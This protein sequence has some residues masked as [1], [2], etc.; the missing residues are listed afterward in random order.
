MTEEYKK[1]VCPEAVSATIRKDGI[2]YDWRCPECGRG[3]GDIDNFCPG[4]GSELDW[5]HQSEETKNF[6]RI[7]EENHGM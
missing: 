4:C 7:M 2:L 1:V 5:E 3:I 6:I